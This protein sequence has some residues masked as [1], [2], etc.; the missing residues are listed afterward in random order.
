MMKP[1]AVLLADD[2]LL[3]REGLAGILRSR[4]NLH[5]VG[6]AAD[7]EEAIKLARELEP[8]LILMDVRMPKVSGLEATRRIKAEMPN[9]HIVMLTMSGEDQDLFEAIKSGAQGY[10]LKNTS[11]DDLVRLI[12]GVFAGEAPLSGSMAMK[13]LAEFNRSAADANIDDPKEE[14]LTDRETQVLNRVAEGLSNREI[15]QA[16][17]VSENTVKK[18]MSHILAKLH[19]QNR[20][21]AALYA[22]K[23]SEGGS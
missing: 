1:I 9:I 10:L 12:E 19:V 17:G 11:S 8:D 4:P 6:G 2:H 7:G 21:Q 20:V 18:Q 23:K 14:A 22:K 5:V 13:I 16:L 3:F 15:A